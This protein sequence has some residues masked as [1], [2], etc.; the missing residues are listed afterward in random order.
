MDKLEKH[1]KN[2]LDQ[3]KLGPSPQAWERIEAELGEEKQLKPTKYYWIGTAAA[4]LLLL[5]LSVFLFTEEQVAG[6]ID[7]KAIVKGNVEGQKE[8]EAKLPESTVEVVGTEDSEQPK[9][10]SKKAEDK[11]LFIDAP[12]KDETA[13]VAVEA[14]SNPDQELSDSVALV[15]DQLIA[16]KLDEVLAMV[17]LMETDSI[18]VTD[19]EIDSL[20]LMAEREILKERIFQ[21]PSKVDALALLDEVEVELYDE[22][23]Y[24]LFIRLKES[25]IKLRTAVAD[26]NN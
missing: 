17:N 11:G 8:Q 10:E 5:M 22:S 13:V 6:E 9:E 1:I 7:P 15:A 25:F 16:D 4:I 2:K 20:L 24:P 3:R 23:R 19:A 26:R 18:L 12:S 14:V 21:D